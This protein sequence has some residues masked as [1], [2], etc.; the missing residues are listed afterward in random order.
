MR[1]AVGLGCCC[2]AAQGGSGM[3]SRGRRRCS[4]R[5]DGMPFPPVIGW[6]TRDLMGWRPTTGRTASSL[7][8]TGH[9]TQT[10]C[11]RG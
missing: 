1:W 5:Q 9:A 3:G 8:R 2:S 7:Q 11:S 4:M 10:P 6:H